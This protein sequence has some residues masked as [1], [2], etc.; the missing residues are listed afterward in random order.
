MEKGFIVLVSLDEL[1]L[2]GSWFV[3]HGSWFLV[4]VLWLGILSMVGVA[5]RFAL[6]R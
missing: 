5:L 3:V 2:L 1:E 4:V 6:S